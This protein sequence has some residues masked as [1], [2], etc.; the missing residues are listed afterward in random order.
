[1]RIFIITHNF[2]YAK[3]EEFLETEVK[4]YKNLEV[5][6]IPLFP[7]SLI[8]RDK[9]IKVD[10][11]FVKQKYGFFQKCECFVKSLFKVQF[12]KEITSQNISNLSKFKILLRSIGRICFYKKNFYKFCIK[13]N[14]KKDDIFY[15]YWNLEETYALC[16]LKDKFGFKL[17]SRIHRQDI[18][19]ENKPFSYMPFKSQYTDLDQI[20]IITHLA[21]EY[22]IK[23]YGFKEN[24]I[25]FSPL[26][27]KDK[28][29][30]TKP[31]NLDEF[32]VVSCSSISRVK[33]IDRLIFALE[34]FA[35]NHKNIKISWFH[36]GSGKLENEIKSLANQK[37]KDIE[38]KF[39]GQLK[40]SE[41]FDFYDKNMVDVFVNV[42]SSE[43]VPVSIMEA[44]SA[45][46]PII[47]PDIG[48][49]SDMVRSGFN[50]ILLNQ[51]F[52]IDELKNAFSKMLLFKDK[53]TRQNSYKIFLE[54]YSA[55]KN[56]SEFVKI[57][58]KGKI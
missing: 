6:F 31:S 18:Y 52:N 51:N 8:T 56:Y 53:N 34:M 49:V 47:A 14:V 36:I 54:K 23:N 26:G 33:Q 42:S 20:F 5:I 9:N 22:L 39:L 58:T 41:I 7:T 48:G 27:V 38:F 25:I 57:I 21:K 29:I 17:V 50:G 45:K 1:M 44:M 32:V 3:G 12:Y 10:N 11:L 40:N 28:S 43:G 2:P 24:Q 30:E 15:T 4:Y 16:E 35:K 46:I 55:D 19:K 37:L 13:N